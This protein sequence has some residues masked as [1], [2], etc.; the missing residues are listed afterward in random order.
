MMGGLA[1]LVGCSS[2][3]QSD[4]G[5]NPACT[6]HCDEGCSDGTREGFT[7]AG[8]WPTLA[9]CQASWSAAFSADGGPGSPVSA[10]SEGWHLCSTDEVAARAASA[11]CA[12]Q[13]GVFSAFGLNVEGQNQDCPQGP[14][15]G[16]YDYKC[17]DTLI[18]VGDTTLSYGACGVDAVTCTTYASLQ[19]CNPGLKCGPDGAFSWAGTNAD[20]GVSD[21]PRGV[22][23]C[24]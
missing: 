3:N 22:L 4:G 17:G 2:S 15:H 1:A 14:C 12:A 5:A 23:C 7:D 21:H 6:A 16:I 10:C 9:G 19:V 8:T 24:Q 11:D 13:P 20:A 18:G